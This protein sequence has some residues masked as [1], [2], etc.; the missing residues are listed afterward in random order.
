M[1]V[2]I[3]LALIGWA[4]STVLLMLAVHRLQRIPAGA[5]MAVVFL[6]YAICILLIALVIFGFASLIVGLAA[7]S[8]HLGGAAGAG[9]VGR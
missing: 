9:G 3:A 5:A 8:M 6:L 1:A 7:G 4:W 2:S